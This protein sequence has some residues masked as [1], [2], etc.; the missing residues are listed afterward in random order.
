MHVYFGRQGKFDY[1]VILT[2]SKSSARTPVLLDSLGGRVLLFSQGWKQTNKSA[3]KPSRRRNMKKIAFKIMTL[4]AAL[5]ALA[6]AAGAG[7]DW[8]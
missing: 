5:V 7:A 1:I 4:V 8:N 2:H 3:S 6:M